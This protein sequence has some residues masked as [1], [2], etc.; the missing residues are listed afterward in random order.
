MCK[1]I[2]AMYKSRQEKTYLGK[3]VVTIRTQ[4]SGSLLVCY[5]Y[6]GENNG[7][8]FLYCEPLN[9]GCMIYVLKTVA[10]SMQYEFI[11]EGDYT[12]ESE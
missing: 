3:F 6:T 10:V 11:V 4:K 12:N 1:G 9:I 2:I 8:A 7:I 5:E